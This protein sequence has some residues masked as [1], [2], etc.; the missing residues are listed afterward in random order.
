MLVT[1]VIDN[2]GL[3]RFYS[4]RWEMAWMLFS[5]VTVMFMLRVNMSVAAPKM[6][7]DLGWTEYEKGLVLVSLSSHS[8]NVSRVSFCLSP[9]LFT[10]Q[11]AF[12]WGYSIGQIP[13]SHLV[14]QYG[15]KWIFGLSI[16]CPSLL[17]FLVPLAAHSSLPLLLFL[18]ALIGFFESAT[19]PAIFYYFPLWVPTE[20]K[21]LMIPAIVSGMYIGEIIGFSL[22]GYLVD[23]RDNLFTLGHWIIGGW[24]S[25]FYIFTLIGV[26]WFPY[27]VL[28]AYDTPEVH[29]YITQE[30]LL[31]IRRGKATVTTGDNGKGENDTKIQPLLF[32]SETIRIEREVGNNDRDSLLS[33][34]E[35][36]SS[37]SDDDNTTTIMVFRTKEERE[38][39]AKRIPWKAF[40]TNKVSLTL[41]VNSWVVVSLYYIYLLPCH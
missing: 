9:C 19:Y 36:G 32:P 23:S 22:S 40:F 27:W 26:L 16:L 1:K 37:G 39:A 3:S 34:T 31:Y 28:R 4:R 17:T 21:T 29:P 10:K 25:V 15:G 38:D 41:F 8:H 12:Y 5:G 20:E 2:V 30:E 24:E 14:Q 35:Q 11:S 13:A 33:C 6:R 7:D 18:R